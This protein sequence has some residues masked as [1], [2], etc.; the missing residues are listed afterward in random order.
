MLADF[1]LAGEEKSQEGVMKLQ[2]RRKRKRE[3]KERKHYI[4]YRGREMKTE[5]ERWV[6]LLNHT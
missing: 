2:G 3:V 4:S 1:T 5:W 6:T